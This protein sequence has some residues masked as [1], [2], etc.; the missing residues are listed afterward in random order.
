[1]E[2]HFQDIQGVPAGAWGVKIS[3]KRTKPRDGGCRI[4]VD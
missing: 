2:N 1:L 3:V 4:L